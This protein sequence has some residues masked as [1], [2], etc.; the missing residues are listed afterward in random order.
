MI[1]LI[2]A[3]KTESVT[4]TNIA[5]ILGVGISSIVLWQKEF[6]AFSTAIKEARDK[7]LDVAE[8]LLLQKMMGGEYV[9]TRVSEI[10]DAKGKVKSQHIEKVTKTRPPDMTALIFYLCNL[11]GEKWK[12]DRD[13]HQPTDSNKI[14]QEIRDFAEQADKIT[15]PVPT[16]KKKGKAK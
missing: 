6:P 3:M 1:P 8:S 7:T 16:K 12:R 9:E 11:R 13:N 4:L 5:R 10:R 15:A 2:L 14:A